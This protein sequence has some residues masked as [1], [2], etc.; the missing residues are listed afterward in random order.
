MGGRAPGPLQGDRC[1]R[2]V[3]GRSERRVRLLVPRRRGVQRRSR[4][5][6]PGTP[7]GK[8]VIVRVPRGTGGAVAER[9][10]TLPSEERITVIE[11]VVVRGETVSE[12]A[13]RYHVET[14][15]VLAANPRVRPQA[16]RV[17][18]RLTIPVSVAR[19]SAHAPARSRR[20][21]ATLG[22]VP[23]RRQMASA[24]SSRFHMVRWGESLWTI[25]RHYGVRVNDL[26]RWN[27]L[28]DDEVLKPGQRLIVTPTAPVTDASEESAR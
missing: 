12:I 26:R 13:K 22:S 1:G 20:S 6:L 2:A 25:A 14:S 27:D 24:V 28:P 23:E 10:A 16:L 11:H 19:A 15:F 4:A 3:A 8:T 9:W 18:Q 17:G 5:H 21:A 7:P